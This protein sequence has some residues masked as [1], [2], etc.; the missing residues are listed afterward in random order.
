MAK[1]YYNLLGV[2]RGAS[3]EEIKKAY[4]KKAHEY[5]P[6]K[7]GGD[8][9]KFKEVNEAYQVLSDP[10]KRKM[11]DQFGEAGVNGAAAGGGAP[12]GINWEDIMR[13]GGGGVE[14]DMGDIF[15]E[16]FG[17]GRRGGR[18]Q[19]QRGADIHMDVTLSFK[20]AAFGLKKTVEL[21]KG[22]KCSKCS[23]NGAEPGT[24]IKDCD[25]CKGSG[26]VEHL[27]RSVFGA[28]RRQAIC[29]QCSGRGKTFE[30]KC[31]T[32]HG[33][34]IEK[35]ESK[36]E[37][38]IPAGI[39]NEQT[40]RVPGQGEAGQFGQ[41]PGDLFVTVHVK[42]HKGW[43]RDGDT[44]YSEVLVPYSTM[45]LGGKISV[46]TLDGEM[47]VKVPSG[48][49][50]GKQLRLR[51]TGVPRLQASGRGDHIVTVQV[52]VPKK[53][54]GKQKKLIKQLADLD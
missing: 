12:G 53:V 31:S 37:I 36:L 49:K 28:V 11:Y 48:M 5:H 4:R 21:L 22:E 16:F 18:G 35:K 24:P 30:T 34:G 1:D 44:I 51:N 54:S 42:P 50:S 26:V 32:C 38:D 17:G 9:A 8:E 33:N 47:E 43:K 2:E 20:E 10:E 6:D 7:E 25:T 52:E 15:S 3:A 13:Q 41:Q 27:Q 40:V 23:G 19:Q 46:E 29:G 14:F 45:V 39:D